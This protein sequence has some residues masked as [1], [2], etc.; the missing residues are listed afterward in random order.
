MEDIFYLVYSV[1]FYSK[2]QLNY[3]QFSEGSEN[4]KKQ[5]VLKGLKRYW[6]FL[7]Q[8]KIIPRSEIWIVLGE[9]RTLGTRFCLEKN[10]TSILIWAMVTQQIK[11]LKTPMTVPLLAVY[12][13]LLNPLLTC[14]LANF[15][16][17]SLS[18]LLTCSNPHSINCPLPHS[19]IW[20]LNHLT[21]WLFAHALK[22]I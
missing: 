5:L 12:T 14:S 21:T 17:Q 1:C 16:A 20:L 2:N 19:I 11:S 13:L 4:D 6:N 18:H 8:L 3:N 15:L 10:I 22:Y 7:I 9:W